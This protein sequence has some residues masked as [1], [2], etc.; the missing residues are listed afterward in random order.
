MDLWVECEVMIF[1]LFWC[2]MLGA[3]DTVWSFASIDRCTSD[4]ANSDRLPI[5]MVLAFHTT[6]VGCSARHMP[7]G[8][9]VVHLQGFRF[10]ALFSCYVLSALRYLVKILR[11][12]SPTGHWILQ[13]FDS[14]NLTLISLRSLNY[15]TTWAIFGAL[16]TLYRLCSL[17][18]RLRTWCLVDL[19]LDHMRGWACIM[20]GW[21]SP[22]WT[23][24]AHGWYTDASNFW[25]RSE[26]TTCKFFWICP[27]NIH[28]LFIL[29]W[30]V[31][32]TRSLFHYSLI[33]PYIHVE[34]LD[35]PN[36]SSTSLGSRIFVFVLEDNTCYFINCFVALLSDVLN[37]LINGILGCKETS[38]SNLLL[39]W[40]Q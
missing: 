13:N 8:P 24:F 2:R 6:S 10:T 4:F 20:H 19:G 14:L 18:E 34:M 29:S 40:I 15:S 9:D 31:T 3:S 27:R 36:T 1:S 30:D 32:N 16:S 26:Y 17:Y 37:S 33:A 23:F 28:L 21:S 35:L 39:K 5:I 38:S 7:F 12:S 22:L 25:S 11:F